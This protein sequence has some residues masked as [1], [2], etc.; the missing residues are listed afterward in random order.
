MFI[1]FDG[2][3]GSGKSTI[4]EALTDRLRKKGKN[5]LRTYEPTDTSVASRAVR[6]YLSSG[7]LIDP[8]VLSDYF[9]QDREEHVASVI[10][11]HLLHGGV[12]ICDRYKYSTLVYQGYQGVDPDYIIQSNA[13][14]PVPDLVFVLLPGSAEVLMNRIA[15]RG[16]AKEVFEKK[17]FL[18]QAIDL[19]KK[20]PVFF[21]DER[22]VFLNADL[23][24]DENLTL[25]EPYVG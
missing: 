25:I 3:D 11:P 18:S 8:K 7:G 17:S 21:P 15:K 19:Y 2:P 23:P 1:V 16:E 24:V 5:V 13:A 10:R 12:V 6:Q 14:F 22:F 4:S 20:L 9:T